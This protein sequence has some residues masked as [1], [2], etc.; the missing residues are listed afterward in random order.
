M[1]THPLIR[2][3]VTKAAVGA[4][5]MTLAVG[6]HSAALAAPPD[7]MASVAAG[8]SHIESVG[9][10]TTFTSLF[11]VETTGGP[12][13]VC[14]GIEV[15]EST[16]PGVITPISFESGCALVTDD[17]LSVDTRGLE[18][19]TLAATTITLEQITCDESGC[20]PS[21]ATRTVTVS[22]TYT[23]VG[24]IGTFRSNS[25]STFGDC[26]MHFLGRG[27]SREAQATI[28]VDGRSLPA[29][30]FLSTSTQKIKVVCS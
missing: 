26:T 5:A 15:V 29:T 2:Q 13:Q 21:G 3:F 7:R 19:A 20:R 27:T 28:V 25:K 12:T 6:T 22:A 14:L 10:V 11:A 17:V 18:A 1:Q 30:G 23:G 24:E 9:N 8:A 4:L 16:A